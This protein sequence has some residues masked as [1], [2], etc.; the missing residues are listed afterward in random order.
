MQKKIKV[1][2]SFSCIRHANEFYWYAKHIDKS[3]FELSCIFYNNEVTPIQD[4]ISSL[5]INCYLVHYKNKYQ[6]LRALYK[7]ILILNRIKPDI[8]HAQLFDASLITLTSCWILGIK[9]RIHTRH[10]SDIHH[11]YHK[12][13]VKY[14]NWINKLSKLVICPSEQTKQI[15]LE[16]EHVYEN[17][18][19]VI[20]HGFDFNDF[21]VDEKK[22]ESVAVKYNIKGFPIIGSVSRFTE[23][24]GVQ[25][26]I[27]AFEKIIEKYPDAL[28]VLAGAEGDYKR[29]IEAEL[30]KL[31][32]NNYR[33]ITFEKEIYSLFSL[34]DIFV[35]V[36]TSEKAE[37]FGQIYVESFYF[38]IPSVITLSGIA[39]EFSMFKKHAKVV[40]FCN[41][42]QIYNSIIEILNDYEFAKKKMNLA[43]NEIKQLFNFD[44]KIKKIESIYLELN[45]Q[46]S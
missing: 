35:H 8:V 5:G 42:N 6:I 27:K 31:S 39:S 15:L 45:G 32:N 30:S 20:P 12:Q 10:H 41:E 36:P 28:L 14:D 17:K 18:I 26:T 7:T 21:I 22:K 4:D 33:I 13:A 11:L 44:I 37:T 25:F 34:F 9:N 3:K 1:V 24:K 2:A 40:D 46:K 16:K 23:W 29:E 38:E 19:R 43:S